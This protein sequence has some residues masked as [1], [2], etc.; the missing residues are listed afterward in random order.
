MLGCTDSIPSTCS[1]PDLDD[2]FG[3]SSTCEFIVQI[4]KRINQSALICEL[5]WS[6][7]GV[8]GNTFG[9]VKDDCKVTCGNCDSK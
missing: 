3:N 4:A 9:L 6:E 5:E 1:F 2:S 7:F 8:C